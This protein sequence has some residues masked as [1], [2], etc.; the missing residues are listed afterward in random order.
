VDEFWEISQA[1]ENEGKRLEL[2]DGEI[3]EMASS[4]KKNTVCAMR[5]GSR[6]SLFVEDH[7][8]GYVTGADGGF[9]IDP[10]NAPQP[11]AAF[12]RKERVK[13]LEGL[14]FEGAPDLAVEVI[15]PSESHA[16]LRRKTRLYLENGAAMV[17]QVYPEEEVVEV[18][19]LNAA[20]E[21]LIRAIE[22]G[23]S[24]SGE[25]IL[26]GFTLALGQIFRP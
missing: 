19:T 17:W 18:C 8:L 6:L 7:D 22:K 14:E 12:I 21:L 13:S 23:G 5:I 4:S 24:L 26:P 16:T 15:S 3:I 20:G 11:D 10:Y 9:R 1:E 25:T 2:I